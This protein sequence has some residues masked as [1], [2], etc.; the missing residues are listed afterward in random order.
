[1]SDPR[2]ITA[3]LGDFSTPMSRGLEQ[4]LSEDSDI[5]VIGGAL[6]PGRLEATV[7]AQS[8]DIALLNGRTGSRRGLIR[9]LTSAHPALRIV[10]VADDPSRSYALGLLTCGVASRTAYKKLNVQQ[11]TKVAAQAFP[12]LV[13]EPSGGAPRLPTGAHVLRYA[14]SNVAQVSLRG[15]KHGLRGAIESTDAM[16]KQTTPSH[17]TPIDLAFDSGGSYVPAAPKVAV[18]IPRRLIHGVCWEPERGGAR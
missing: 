2:K 16:A 17:F 15:G 10:V 11:V 18:R 4:I 12:K 6:G 7:R 3:V 1:M 9:N 5:E 14:S 8:S 13:S